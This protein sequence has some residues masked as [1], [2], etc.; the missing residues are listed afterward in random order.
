MT[1]C[2]NWK[3]PQKSLSQLDCTFG[4]TEAPWH[5]PGHT[6]SHRARTDTH[7]VQFQALRSREC[8]LDLI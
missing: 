2:H 8:F 4:E 1:Q 5:T 3:G 7:V 6:G